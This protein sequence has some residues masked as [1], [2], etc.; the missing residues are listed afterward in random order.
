[1][2]AV[3]RTTVSPLRTTT[4]PLACLASLP[5]SNEISSSPT[6]A[7]TRVV[8]K[9]LIGYF[10]TSGRPDGDHLSLELSF[11]YRCEAYSPG[12]AGV[13]PRK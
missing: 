2:V 13:I 4:E 1:M 7:E 3:E 12:T 5:V 10:S 9:M 6:R 8:S 11:S